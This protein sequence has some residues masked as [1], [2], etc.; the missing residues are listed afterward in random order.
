MTGLV[1]AYY[2]SAY[3][4]N[5]ITILERNAIPY[6]GTSKQNGNWLP[7]DF[8][9]SWVNKPVY[10]FVYRAIFD[11]KNFVS[12]IYLNTLFENFNNSLI[13]LKFAFKWLL[14]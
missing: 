2:L 5:K 12:K 1:T 8:A 7:I 3:P 4:H 6:Q 13:T 11:N 9:Y 10:P 14:F